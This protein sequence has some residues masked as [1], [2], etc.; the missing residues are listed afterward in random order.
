M[1][2]CLELTF[3]W[4]HCLEFSLELVKFS[5]AYARK[6]TGGVFRYA[7]CLFYCKKTIFYVEYSLRMPRIDQLASN[8]PTA[9]V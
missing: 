7:L 1:F 9:T 3:H 4:L 2:R 5:K 8:R 6:Q